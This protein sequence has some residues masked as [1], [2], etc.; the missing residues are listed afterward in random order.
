MPSC[1]FARILPALAV[2]VCF[3]ALLGL[4][5]CARQ[6]TPGAAPDLIVVSGKI[7][8]GGGAGFAEAVAVRGNAILRVG[9]NQEI[10]A[11]AGPVTTV[12]DARGGAVV[13]GL[14]DSRLHVI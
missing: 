7:Y 13:P 12:I 5:A 3:L 6:E 8:P 1:R 14:N 10:R 9:T 2:A 11:L 4:A